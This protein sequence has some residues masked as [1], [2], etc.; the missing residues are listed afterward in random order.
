MI[1]SISVATVFLQRGLWKGRGF[2]L[3][4]GNKWSFPYLLA[5][6]LPQD[7]VC[8]LWSWGVARYL[9]VWFGQKFAC[10]QCTLVTDA[11]LKFCSIIPDT[12][13]FVSISLDCHRNY[14]EPL[15]QEVSCANALLNMT[16]FMY[17]LANSLI[18]NTRVLRGTQR[19]CE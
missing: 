15:S 4:G 9:P 19:L 12:V 13:V 16:G 11:V 10:L 18:M 6:F 14:V 1:Y 5:G 2:G 7:L 3:F 8:V 17:V